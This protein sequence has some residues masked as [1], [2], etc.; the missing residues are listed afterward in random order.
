MELRVLVEPALPGVVANHVSFECGATLEE[1]TKQPFVYEHHGNGFGPENQG[2]LTRFFEDLMAGAVFPLTFG[3]HSIRDVDTVFAIALF[4]NRDLALVPGMVN[5]VAQMDLVHRRGV[6]MLAHLDPFMVSFVR[7]LRAYF[8]DDLPKAEM[9]GRIETAARWIRDLATDGA[10]P[11]TG[12]HKL[13]DVLVLDK[14]S[15][16]FVV[17][18]TAGDLVEG[19]IV[20]FSQG[21][22][23]GVLVSPERSGRRQVLAVRKSRFVPLDVNTAARLLNDVES[24]MGEPP[25]WAC[26]AEWLFGP[27]KGTMLTLAHMMEVFLRV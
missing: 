8:P 13:P 6:S 2:A 14:G 26:K 18:E 25:E 5:L 19:W 24:A 10:Y 27:S 23:R 9:G 15:G 17:A 11:P 4:L 1:T 21:F 12:N 22:V 3:T 16:G 20:L 7:L